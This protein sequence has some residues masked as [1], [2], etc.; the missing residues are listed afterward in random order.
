MDTSKEPVAGG[1]KDK[2]HKLTS[3]EKGMYFTRSVC[4]YS[5]LNKLLI[6][7]APEDKYV[8]SRQKENRQY[9][10]TGSYKQLVIY[11]MN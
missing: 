11:I 8:L 3:A 7:R 5:Y 1:S 4:V 9:T 2:P 6:C 10:S